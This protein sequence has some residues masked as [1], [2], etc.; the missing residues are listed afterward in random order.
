[1]TGVQARHACFR[2][3]LTAL[4][5]PGRPQALPVRAEQAPRL[6]LDSVWEES[7]LGKDVFLLEADN[8]DL[9][10]AALPRGDEERPEAGATV[11]VSAA[12]G[13][14]EGWIE[15]P[16]VRARTR[17]RLPVSAH[18]L[19]DRDRACAEPPAGI[20]LLIVSADGSVIGLPRTTRLA[21]D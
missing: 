16:G 5:Y 10:L 19:S 12:G 4:A 6:I 20:D 11:I 17:V 8:V 21:L 9:D 15:G 2:A 1:M 13:S 14:V 18:L 3:V 7:Q